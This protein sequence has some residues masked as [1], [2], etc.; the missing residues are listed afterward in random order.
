MIPKQYLPLLAVLFLS[1]CPGP[2]SPPTPAQTLTA[3]ETTESLAMA[4]ITILNA[5]GDISKTDYTAAQEADTAF[6]TAAT[7]VSGDL[8]A[9]QPLTSADVTSM[10]STVL[11]A[12]M[13]IHSTL[14]E[15][16]A[17]Q[18]APVTAPTSAS[19]PKKPLPPI[20]PERKAPPEHKPA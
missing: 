16:A 1:G 15:K 8:S 5:T 12:V 3:I 13:Q 6:Q 2:T 7:T 4:G 18:P 9:G 11:S 19:P 10:L 20:K 14:A 17:T